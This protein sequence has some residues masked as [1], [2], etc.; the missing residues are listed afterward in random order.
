[1]LNRTNYISN[2]MKTDTYKENRKYLILGHIVHEYVSTGVPVSSKVVAQKMGGRISS[3]T[4]RNVMAELEE[5]GLIVQP[6]TSA[7]RVPTD[8]GYRCY[9]DIV[10][11][12]IRF[13]KQRARRL[14]EEYS[15]RIRTMKDV[16]AKTSFLI[17]R[18]LHNAGVVMWP[19]LEDFYLKH[20]ELVKLKAERVMAI[21]VTMTNDVR[22]HIISLDRELKET[23]LER[24]A[25]FINSN[26]ERSTFSGITGDLRRMLQGSSGESGQVTEIART[27][28]AVIDSIIEEDIENEIYW[29]GLNYFMESDATRDLDLTK[30]ILRIFSAKNNL[31]RLLRRD[32]SR[33]GIMVHIGEEEGRDY[34]K[35]CSLITCGYTLRGRV[36]GRIGV[37]GPTRMDYDG[38][39]STVR[40]LSELLSEKLKEINS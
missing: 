25:N 19:S 17:C 31:A 30:R 12:Q 24:V 18:E 29:E 7:G 26:Y 36:I 5:K 34:L 28:L 37:I 16:I 4:V 2:I 33:D 21:L 40:C 3:A 23:E 35:G 22:N 38:A 27:A 15:K 11:D 1:V 39:M 20:M 10:K 8:H 13:E 14:A 32:L 6:H 9:V